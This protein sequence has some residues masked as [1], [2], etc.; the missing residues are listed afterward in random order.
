MNRGAGVTCGVLL[1]QQ[2]K[3]FLCLIL[4]PRWNAIWCEVWLSVCLWVFVSGWVCV[5]ENLHGSA[6][7]AHLKRFSKCR[8]VHLIKRVHCWLHCFYHS[9]ISS[10]CTF[11]TGYGE[12]VAG[13]SHGWATIVPWWV[14][15]MSHGFCS[16]TTKRHCAQSTQ[17][18][19]S[20][21]QEA[22]RLAVPAGIVGWNQNN[23]WIILRVPV[24]SSPLHK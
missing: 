1:N 10:I 2:F 14:L 7:I 12:R 19:E 15:S 21:E 4:A 11:W 20:R 22:N 23:G 3:D 13:D 18:S 17:H 8:A 24:S 9:S 16:V 6:Y 5:R